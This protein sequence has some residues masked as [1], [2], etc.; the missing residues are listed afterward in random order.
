MRRARLSWCRDKPARILPAPRVLPEYNPGTM[1]SA[2]LIGFVAA[3]LTTASFVPQAWHTWRTR[4]L[5][6][7]SLTMYAMF[8]IGVALWLVYGIVDGAWPVIIAN[9]VTLVLASTILAMKLRS[10]MAS[11]ARTGGTTMLRGIDDRAEAV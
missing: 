8:T 5:S 4:D 2:D 1:P 3:I 6:G 10:V 7:I 11:P 9:L